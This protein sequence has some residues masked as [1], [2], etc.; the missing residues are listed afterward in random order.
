MTSSAIITQ[1]LTALVLAVPVAAVSWTVTHE[2]V[3]REPRE[4]LTRRSRVNR[5]WYVRK[6]FYLFTCEY[7]F[8]HYVTIAALAGTRFTLLY[9]DWRGFVV[10]GFSIVWFANVYMGLFGRLRLEVK[11]E[12]TEIAAVESALKSEAGTRPVESVARRGP[13]A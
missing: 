8:S 12:R 3:L 13:R 1:V 2:E 9:D 10:A 4:W 11:H 6:F 5:R 7:C